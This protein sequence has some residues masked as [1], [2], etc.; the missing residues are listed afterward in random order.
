MS[1]R[2]RALSEIKR[3]QSRVTEI[4]QVMTSLG[5]LMNGTGRRRGRSA[6]TTARSGQR[7][8]RAPREG[9]IGAAIEGFLSNKRQP[10]HADELMQHLTGGGRAPGGKNPKA[11]LQS[12]LRQLEQRGRVQNTGRNR[13]KLSA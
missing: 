12:T 4:D 5:S 11:S 3:L 10:V 6:T 7:G 9:T 2:E 1:E 13:W 8:G